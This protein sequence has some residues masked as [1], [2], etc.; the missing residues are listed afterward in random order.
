M[1][2]DSFVDFGT[3]TGANNAV[4]VNSIPASAH[5]QKNVILGTFNTASTNTPQAYAGATF[6]NGQ[7]SVENCSGAYNY[8]NELNMVAADSTPQT[9][10]AADNSQSWNIEFTSAKGSLASDVQGLV[11][12]LDT[13][14]QAG[15]QVTN[16]ISN[17]M[18]QVHLANLYGE[19]QDGAQ[20]GVSYSS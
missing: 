2:T 13:A 9:Q 18:N 14:E 15:Q 19:Q 4:V 5:D 20:G 16:G 6:T 17:H 1:S 7:R 12:G 10:L 8:H 11:A 3:I